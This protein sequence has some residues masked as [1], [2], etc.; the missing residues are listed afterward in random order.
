MSKLSGK[1]QSL[2]I[3]LVEQEKG[4]VIDDLEDV[5]SKGEIEKL[6]DEINVL[7]SLKSAISEKGELTPD[8]SDKATNLLFMVTVQALYN[9]NDKDPDD[10]YSI[11]LDLGVRDKL[12]SL[13]TIYEST[14][15]NNT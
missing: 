7:T 9:G 15:Y 12:Q 2:F 4:S 5:E 8:E 10:F 3:D 6:E 14:V 13:V 11:A 1:K